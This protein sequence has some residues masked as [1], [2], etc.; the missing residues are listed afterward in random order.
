[1]IR[2]HPSLMSALA[3]SMLTG[4]R[5]FY[6]F[7]ATARATIKPELALATRTRVNDT[8]RQLRRRHGILPAPPR[9]EPPLGDQI[10][11]GLRVH[12][13]WAIHDLKKR[14]FVIRIEGGEFTQ[15][16]LT[17]PGRDYAIRM[18]EREAKGFNRDY[19]PRKKT[20]TPE[21]KD[22]LDAC[23][24]GSEEHHCSVSPEI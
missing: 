19:T 23:H 10:Y 1:M 8:E 20:I 12:V 13:Q 14:Q 22:Q 4:S 7:I 6:E 21:R 16:G 15:W 3:Q 11:V 2:Q 5:T 17:E 24:S 18:M 9:P